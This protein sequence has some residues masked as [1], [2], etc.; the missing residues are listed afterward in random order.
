MSS[1]CSNLSHSH[2]QEWKVVKNEKKER[3][4]LRLKERQKEKELWSR[5]L[6]ECP[7]IVTPDK[8]KRLQK[9]L[10]I[11]KLES[12]LLSSEWITYQLRG[13]RY[14]KTLKRH[15]R[16]IEEMDKRE[17]YEYLVLDLENGWGDR[18]LFCRP[19]EI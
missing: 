6:N 2:F 16:G 13:W 5:L 10:N 3:R 1:I 15:K 14:I 7:H 9:M 4:K 17:G 12:K 18:A 19:V 8:A 11:D